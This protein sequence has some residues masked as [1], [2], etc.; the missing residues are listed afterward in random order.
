MVESEPHADITSLDISCIN[1]EQIISDNNLFRCNYLMTLP[2]RSKV[3]KYLQ[4]L[5]YFGQL[6]YITYSFKM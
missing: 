5:L 6:F 4:I 1:E 3:K 2:G